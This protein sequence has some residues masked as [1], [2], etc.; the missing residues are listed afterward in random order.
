VESIFHWYFEQKKNDEVAVRSRLRSSH[1]PGETAAA[2]AREL[3]PVA[4][5]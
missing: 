5:P 1:Y 3:V 2:E 4:L